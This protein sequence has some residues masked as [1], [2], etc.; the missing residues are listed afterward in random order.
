M[1]DRM[2]KDRWFK[3]QI[4]L[5]PLCI[6]NGPPLGMQ[7]YGHFLEFNEAQIGVLSGCLFFLSH[8]KEI[9]AKGASIG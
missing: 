4:P 3:Y 9:P 5:S 2:V 8:W 1:H 6:D 7:F